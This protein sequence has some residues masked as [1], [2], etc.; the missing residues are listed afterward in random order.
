MLYFLIDNIYVT[1]GG[2]IFQQKIGIPMDT[3]LFSYSY[4]TEFLQNF[5]KKRYI[6]DDTSF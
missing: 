4:E 2:V 5:V 3:N 1:F 6:K